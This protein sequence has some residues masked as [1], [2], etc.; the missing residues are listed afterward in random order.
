V[1]EHPAIERGYIDIL[2]ELILLPTSYIGM[3]VP[4]EWN[5]KTETL[6]VL[7][8]HDQTAKPIKTVRFAL[9]ECTKRMV[10]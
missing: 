5:L 8:E 6:T 1:Y 9:N 3:F 10:Y 4:A 7:Y 2:K